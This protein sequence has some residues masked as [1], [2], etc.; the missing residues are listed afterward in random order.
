MTF[1]D[2]WEFIPLSEMSNLINSLLR[3]EVLTANEIRPKI[4]F[5]PHADPNADKLS[6]ANMPGGNNAALD[7]NGNLLEPGTEPDPPPDTTQPLFD[8]MNSILD[9]AFNDLGMSSD[10]KA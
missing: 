10:A 4:G 9:K 2:Q 1:W 7:A 6:N 5:K 8:Q 3:N